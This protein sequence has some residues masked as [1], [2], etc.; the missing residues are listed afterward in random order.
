MVWCAIMTSIVYD[1]SMRNFHAVSEYIFKK[2][3]DKQQRDT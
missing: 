2:E 3:T 1:D